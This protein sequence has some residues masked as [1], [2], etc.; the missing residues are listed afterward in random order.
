MLK[1]YADSALV[2]GPMMI[3]TVYDGFKDWSRRTLR[4][5]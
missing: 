5:H 3:T 2:G 1:A 4:K